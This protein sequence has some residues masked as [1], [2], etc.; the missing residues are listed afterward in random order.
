GVQGFGVGET[1][2]AA[3]A[4]EVR[5]GRLERLEGLPGQPLGWCELPPSAE[6]FVLTFRRR[7]HLLDLEGLPQVVMTR[8][9]E[10]SNQEDPALSPLDLGTARVDSEARPA[11]RR[12]G[13]DQALVLDIVVLEKEAHASRVGGRI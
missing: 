6:R 2:D 13:E 11:E 9:A 10:A 4:D 12:V 3:E 7:V 8:P 5:A 1:V